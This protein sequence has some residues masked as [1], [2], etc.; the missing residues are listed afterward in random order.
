MQYP[1]LRGAIFKLED[2]PEVKGAIHNFIPEENFD[3]EFIYTLK[4]RE[5]AFYEIWKNNHR[6]IVSAFLTTID[7]SIRTGNSCG[8]SLYF[9]GK[10]KNWDLILAHNNKEGFLV[11]FIE[12]YI[13][14]GHSLEKMLDNY[15]NAPTSRKI[16]FFRQWC[17]YFIKYQ[18]IISNDRGVYAWKD[19]ENGNFDI[20]RLLSTNTLGGWH[21][22]PFILLVAEKV[23]C[24]ENNIIRRLKEG[25]VYDYVYSDDTRIYDCNNKSLM[26]KKDGVEISFDCMENGWRIEPAIIPVNNIFNFE[27]SDITINSNSVSFYL[28][29]TE[30][31]DMIEV[32]VAFIC[33]LY[34]LDNPLD[35]NKVVDSYAEV[36]A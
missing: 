12:S 33:E 14:N 30:T 34:Q 20:R 5:E 15:L 21:I 4:K 35:K 9:F 19:E 10:E 27:Y 6:L 29:P 32:A 18:E 13:Y 16:D 36:V 23:R 26:L 22:N 11:N 24:I 2:H 1:E 7:Y 17:F 31:M 25:E 8:K 28:Q 3:D